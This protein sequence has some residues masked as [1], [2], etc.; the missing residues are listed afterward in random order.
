[1]SFF[2]GKKERQTEELIKQHIVLVGKAVTALHHTAMD[3]CADCKEYEEHGN[4]VSQAESDADEA[5]RQ[6]EQMIYDGA[7]M[8]VQRGD[9]AVLMDCIDKIANQCEAVAQ[10]MMLTCPDLTPEIKDGLV[11]IMEAT[12]RCYS[13]I[14]KMFDGFENGQAVMTAA[15][16]VEEEEQNVDKLFARIVSHLFKSDLDLAHKIHIKM[17]L[18][19]SAAVSNRIEDASD[20]FSIMVSKRL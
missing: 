12:V 19:R 2:G 14:P 20:R 5:R 8:P 4:E 16:R 11:E 18:D 10:F 15:H 6:A 17:L 1:M 9:Y 13:H 3:Y 7:F